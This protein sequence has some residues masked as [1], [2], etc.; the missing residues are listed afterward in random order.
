MMVAPAKAGAQSR[1]PAALGLV[2]TRGGS[3]M[4]RELPGGPARPWH[5]LAAAVRAAAVEDFCRA[6]AAERAFERADDR[7]GRLRRQVAV[8]AFTIRTKLEHARVP[9]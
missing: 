4:L 8:A 7:V 1:R 5:E 2:D 3:G 9:P 6:V